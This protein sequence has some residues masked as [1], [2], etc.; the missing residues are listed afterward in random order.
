MT[1]R[2]TDMSRLDYAGMTREPG[3]EC[4]CAAELKK[5]PLPPDL[6]AL[7]G[8]SFIWT[9]VTTGD[10]RCYPDSANTEDRAITAEPAESAGA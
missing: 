4:F 7:S 1:G 3:P 10:T 5:T 8:R 6:A 2:E 9:H